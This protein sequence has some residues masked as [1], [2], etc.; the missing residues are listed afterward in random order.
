[1][2]PSR[3]TEFLEKMEPSSVS[4]FASA[5][6]IRRNQDTDF[7]FRQET[8]FYYLTR[9]NEPDCVAV[10]APSHPE[11]KYVLF[12][13]PR[14]REEEIWTGLRAGV[15]GAIRDHGA[16]AAY[17]IAQLGELL[18]K[19]LQNSHK[20]YYRFGQNQQ[21]DL[22]VIGTIKHIRE[23]V[24]G[25]VYAPTTIIDPSTIV[26]EMRLRK[27]EDD[28]KSLRRAA[29]ISAEGHV[30]AM[31]HCK[32]GMYEYELEALVEYVFRKNGATGV[33][34]PSIVGSGFN[35][36]I[37]HYN[38]NQ[39]QIQDGDMVLIDAGAEYD[40][41]SGDI[42]RSFPANGKFTKA[43]QAIYEVVLNANKEVIKMIKP[44]E[45]FMKL[46]EHSVDVV[47]QGLIDIGLLS[48]SLKDNVEKKAYEKFFMHR[49][50]HWLGMD[51]HDVGRYKLDD[52]WRRL[53]PGMVFTV[54][55]G[56]YIAAGA[57]NVPEEFFNIGVRIEDD[58]VVTENGVEVLTAGVP[59][60]AREIEAI[61]K[62]SA[63]VAV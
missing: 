21:F 14:K 12:V 3:L 45:S 4:V 29:T 20:L 31:K 23:K 15:E 18:P 55:P 6:E 34:Y 30:A 57:E 56:V 42:T 5:H 7:E 13:R 47:T 19:Y 24:R 53:E 16:D 41:F 61:M 63:M 52:D 28:L 38:T 46:H 40:V 27:N 33:G 8:D 54:E 17:D 32:P 11:H 2:R 43:Q 49:T 58:V 22:K 1:M 25:G 36:T 37:L 10:L 50:G 35:T 60:E 48:G 39:C 51:V 62:E 26:H 59:K 44:G 9:L